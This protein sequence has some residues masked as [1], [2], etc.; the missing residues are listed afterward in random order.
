MGVLGLGVAWLLRRRSIRWQLSLVAIVAA[1]SV[2]AGFVAAARLMFISEHDLTVVILVAV[3][4]GVVT[5][6]VALA[7]VI[8]LLG[9]SA[10]RRG[11]RI[12][13]R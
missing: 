4:A 10:L 6:A 11:K 8:P 5:V 3:V 1:V 9:G 13:A 12:L 2:L 7:A